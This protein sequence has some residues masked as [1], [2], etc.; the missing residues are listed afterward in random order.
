MCVFMFDKGVILIEKKDGVA[1]EE[2]MVNVIG[3]Q[4]V[5]DFNVEDEYYEIITRTR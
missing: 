3:V 5:E 2:L 1:E 4:G